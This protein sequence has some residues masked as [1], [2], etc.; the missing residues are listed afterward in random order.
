[1]PSPVI[2][3]LAARAGLPFVDAHTIDTF[4]APAAGEPAHAVL[5]FTG[6][7]SQ[8]AETNDVAVVLPEL[9]AAFTGRLRA[10]IITRGAEAALQARFHVVVMPSLA[11]TRAET[12]VGVLPRVRDWSD[13]IRTIERCL[14]PDAPA[15]I[16]GEKPEVRITRTGAPA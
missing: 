14:A 16:A 11:V 8:R 5:F 3:A 2:R 1:M 15:L 6:D 10:A 9:L 13:Y 12:P 4:L 7:P